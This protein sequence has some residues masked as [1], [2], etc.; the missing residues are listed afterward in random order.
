MMKKTTSTTSHRRAFTQI[1]LLVV[2]VVIAAL[3]MVLVVLT[4]T[5]HRQPASRIRCT[6]NLRELGI[7]FR[8]FS[9]DNYDQYPP[10]VLTNLPQTA[11]LV[12]TCF[13]AASNNLASPKILICPTDTRQPAASLSSLRN[14]NIS[15]F[16]SLTAS[17]TEPASFLCGDRN[18]TNGQA[19]INGVLELRKNQVVGW[20]QTMHSNCGNVVLADGSVQNVTSSGLQEQLQAMG[21]QT[22]RIALP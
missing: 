17:E 3:I 4:P 16:V 8:L 15:Y 7:A 13:R 12:A 20:D 2:I 19:P 11:E 22:N 10:A 5:A 14:A 1:E 6:S 18:L 9:A 21:N